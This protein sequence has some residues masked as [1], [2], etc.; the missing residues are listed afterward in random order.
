MEQLSP[1]KL[2]NLLKMTGIPVEELRSDTHVVSTFSVGSL[3]EWLA[4]SRSLLQREQF[5]VGFFCFIFDILFEKIKSVWM[6][7]YN[8]NV[9]IKNWLFI[10]PSN[11]FTDYINK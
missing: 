3:K 6:H 11:I 4:G 8:Y 5:C 2:N 7:T 10:L 9:I 1:E